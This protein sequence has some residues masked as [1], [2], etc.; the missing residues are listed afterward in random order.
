MQQSLEI[1]HIS[2]V[3]EPR[4]TQSEM[5]NISTQKDVKIPVMISVSSLPHRHAQEN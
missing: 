2:S 1:W 3:K 4:E 5:L